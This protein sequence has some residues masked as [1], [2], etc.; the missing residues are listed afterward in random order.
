MCI[1]LTISAILNPVT[2][3]CGDSWITKFLHTSDLVLSFL[4][5]KKR[6]WD[7]VL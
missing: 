5:T 6:Y 3:F 4:P 1:T 2:K 7:N